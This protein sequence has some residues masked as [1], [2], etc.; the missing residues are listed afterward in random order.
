M[1]LRA[2]KCGC[3]YFVPHFTRS[4]YSGKIVEVD[5]RTNTLGNVRLRNVVTDFADFYAA[6]GVGPY[7]GQVVPFHEREVGSQRAFSGS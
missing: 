6:G 7:D 2:G 1:A 4:G 3:A 5:L